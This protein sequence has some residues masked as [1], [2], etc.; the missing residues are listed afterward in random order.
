MPSNREGKVFW[1]IKKAYIAIATIASDGSATFGSPRE[2][3]GAKSLTMT[4]KGESGYYYADDIEYFDLQSN[5]GYE[6]N[7][8]MARIL[9]VIK[10]DILGYIQD[11]KGVLYE[12]K[13]ADP[14]HFA[15]LFESTTDQRPTRYVYYN[16]TASRPEQSHNTKEA[17]INPGTEKLSIISKPIYIPSLDKWV[18]SS[19]T[20]KDTDDTVFND[21]FEE[22]YVPT[23]EVTPGEVTPG[24]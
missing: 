2:I 11:S 8:E 14:V 4:P 18:P 10:T 1:G 20:T 13:N 9:D 5:E 23:P 12:N 17:A 3:P 15:L 24:T 6:G 7:W 16:C 21:W 19:V 22:V